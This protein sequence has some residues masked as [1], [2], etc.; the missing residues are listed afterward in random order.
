MY[1]ASIFMD[2]NLKLEEQEEA[3]NFWKYYQQLLT[4][5]HIWSYQV[6][7]SVEKN[8]QNLAEIVGLHP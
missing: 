5:C 3:K 7:Q 2:S 4:L 1:V 6:R 8:T